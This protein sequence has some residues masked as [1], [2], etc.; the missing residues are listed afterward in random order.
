MRAFRI[1][2]LL[3][4]ALVLAAVP[5]R[6]QNTAIDSRWIGYLG[7]WQSVGTNA[8]TVCLLPVDESSVDL[9]TIESGAVVTAERIT[10]GRRVA[11]AQ[12]E[13]TGWQMA[14]WSAVSDRLYLQSEETC[15]RSGTRAANGLI[16][17]SRD[18]SLL[19]IQGGT[20]GLKTGVQ[21]QRYREGTNQELPSEV[22]DARNAIRTDLI[23]ATRARATA[24]ARL[25]IE[26]V[27]EA[28]RHLEPDVV[29]AWLMERGG[30]ITLDAERL[31]AMADAGVPSSTIDVLVALAYPN[32]FAINGRHGQSQL[33]DYPPIP[34]P[35]LS[36]FDACYLDFAFGSGSPYCGGFG[37]YYGYGYP[38]YYPGY[39]YVIVYTGG[40]P[41]GGGGGDRARPHGRVV[42]GQGYRE[43]VGASAD[44]SRHAEP[45]SDP[46]G[47]SSG[48][49]STRTSTSSSGSGE[50]RTAKPRP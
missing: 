33:G 28:S 26:D 16:A 49:T 50:Q 18:G 9:V 39:P 5:A 2:T 40:S 25:T 44:V 29:E 21:V 37:G 43:G 38:G 3:A 14:D 27:A 24:M 22:Q 1:S 13:C 7:C 15:P 35:T 20:I 45:R 8:T 30:S 46:V 32:A 11:T 48:G 41:S 19:Y 31:V 10:A 17:L 4:A 42:N 23:A 6:G 34:A 47:S 36:I 12:G